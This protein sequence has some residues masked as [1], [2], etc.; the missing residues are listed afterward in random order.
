M[1]LLERSELKAVFFDWGDTI[2]VNYPE[3]EGP[4]ASWPVV[5]AVPGAP[6]AL[7]ALSSRYVLGL[8]T[9]AGI[10]DTRLVRLALARLE[11]EDLFG[12]VL[13]S[14]DLGA[15][16]PDLVFFTRALEAV[17]CLPCEAVMVGDNYEV[18]IRGAKAAGLRTVWYNPTRAVT[19]AGQEH[20]DAV[21]SHLAD[22]PG[23]L[24]DIQGRSCRA[25]GQEPR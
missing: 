11:L 7:R 10:S 6:E 20:H 15:K 25:S 3:Y 8:L 14:Q 18:D 23:A 17:G 24:V 9:N 13:T 2:M 19:P 12:V 16:K 1:R 21:I 22:L 5:S 4:M